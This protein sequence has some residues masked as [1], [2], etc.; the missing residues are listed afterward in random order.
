M[1]IRLRET[2]LRLQVKG[3]NSLTSSSYIKGWF[4]LLT[5]KRDLGTERTERTL[6]G[7]LLEATGV[8]GKFM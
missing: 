2:G 1:Q 5:E 4:D 6:N 3:K 7:L 8:T